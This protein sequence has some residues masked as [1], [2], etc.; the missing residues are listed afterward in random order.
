MY[1]GVAGTKITDSDWIFMEAPM[2]N[3]EIS[4]VIWNSILKDVYGTTGL[5]RLWNQV[6]DPCF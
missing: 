3:I 1:A 4:A 6:H 5:L 2:I